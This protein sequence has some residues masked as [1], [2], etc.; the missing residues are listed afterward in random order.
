MKWSAKFG[1]VE[2]NICAHKG[3]IRALCY[4]SNALVST[5]DDKLL[6]LWDKRTLALMWVVEGHTGSRPE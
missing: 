5:G 3:Y 1:N 4:C 6:K 2:K